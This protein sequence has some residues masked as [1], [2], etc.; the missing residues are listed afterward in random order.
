MKFKNERPG[1]CL[2]LFVCLFV[3]SS[4][5]GADVVVSQLS[6]AEVGSSGADQFDRGNEASSDVE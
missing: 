3:F 1:V 5:F 4:C 2:A 6:V